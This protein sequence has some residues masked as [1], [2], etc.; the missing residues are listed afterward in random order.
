MHL[1]AGGHLC[2]NLATGFDKKTYSPVDSADEL[3]ARPFV[4]ALIY[5]VIP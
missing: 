3:L 1:S 5:P 2:A 4:A